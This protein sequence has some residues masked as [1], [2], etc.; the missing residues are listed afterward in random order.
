[1]TPLWGPQAWEGRVARS[2]LRHLH[3]HLPSLRSRLVRWMQRLWLWLWLWKRWR[4]NP[5]GSWVAELLGAQADVSTGLH[6]TGGATADKRTITMTIVLHQS[7]CQEAV[8]GLGG[9]HTVG[10]GGRGGCGCGCGGWD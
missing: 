4:P 2:Q 3:L 9:A 6:K 10:R 8:G 1:V 7:G 5:L